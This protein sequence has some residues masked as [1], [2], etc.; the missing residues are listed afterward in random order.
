M[1]I[2]NIKSRKSQDY[3]FTVDMNCAEDVIS[4]GQLKALIK[5]TNRYS[6]RPQRVVLKGRLGSTENPARAKYRGKYCY[7]VAKADAEYFDV[8]VY[9]RS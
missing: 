3:R 1:N 2:T 4:L 6:Y 8:Y 9:D 5:Q 7:T